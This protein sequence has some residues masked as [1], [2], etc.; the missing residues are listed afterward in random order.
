MFL[1]VTDSS[2]SQSHPHGHKSHSQVLGSA[3]LGALI[4][5][6]LGA[7]ISTHRWFGWKRG[8]TTYTRSAGACISIFKTRIWLPSFAP[9]L[10]RLKCHVSSIDNET[11]GSYM[12][13]R[14]TVDYLHGLMKPSLGPPTPQSRRDLS[15]LSSYIYKWCITEPVVLT[16]NNN[17]SGWIV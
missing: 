7:L 2:S 6:S 13:R 15:P 5:A 12:L 16:T 14:Q 8:P 9:Y 3:S 4:C 17:G 11:F 10:L 1:S